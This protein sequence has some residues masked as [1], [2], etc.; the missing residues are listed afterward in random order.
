MSL[1]TCPRCGGLR[2]D[3]MRNLGDDRCTCK[4]TDADTGPHEVPTLVADLRARVTELERQVD[5]LMGEAGLKG[6]RA[7]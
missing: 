7:L 3:W 5:L 4:V 6:A 2:D 1:T